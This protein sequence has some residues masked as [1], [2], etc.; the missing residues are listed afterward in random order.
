MIELIVVVAVIGILAALLLPV[1]SKAKDQGVRTTCI[2]NLK[3]IT[4]TMHL[5]ATDHNGEL[6]WSNWFRG[7]QNGRSGWL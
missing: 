7:D 1:L 3:Q 2:N 4:T 6:P 5:Y